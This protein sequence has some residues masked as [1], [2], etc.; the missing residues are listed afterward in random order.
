MWLKIKQEGLIPQ[1]LVPMVPLTR[2]T[3]F[4]IPVF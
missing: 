4:G 3:H 2:A 1:V